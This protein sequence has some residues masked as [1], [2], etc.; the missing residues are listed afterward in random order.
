ARLAAETL[1]GRVGRFVHVS[2]CSVYWCTGDFP[3]PVPEEDFDRL[4]DFSE[5]PTSIE[6]DYGYN[7]R[8]AEEALFEA[9][10][11]TGF[12]F[13]AVRLPIVG[14]EGDLSLRCA[15][16]CRRVGDGG[17]LALPDGGWAP[18]RQVYVGD[19]VRTLAALPGA[20][21]AVGQAY[22]LAGAEILS[23]RAIVA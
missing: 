15:S 3:C 10:G 1:A 9:H 19:V 8:K 20:P 22:N 5:R 14:G 12:P 2:T 13:T 18:L 16:Y 4:G 17:P 11:Q 6:Y 21:H 23:V 7:K